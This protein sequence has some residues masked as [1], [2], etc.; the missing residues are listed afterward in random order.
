MIAAGFKIE[1]ERAGQFRKWANGI[2][3]DCT[4]QGW[5]MDAERLKRGGTLTDEFFERQL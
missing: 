5:T 3:K 4:I 1:N 2:V